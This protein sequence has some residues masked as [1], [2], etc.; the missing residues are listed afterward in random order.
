MKANQ[1]DLVGSPHNTTDTTNGQAANPTGFNVG[2]RVRH[3][4][5][6]IQKAR[7]YWLSCGREPMKT[8]ARTDLDKKTSARGTVTAVEQGKYSW[9]VAV[10]WDD[11][12]TSDGL[13]YMISNAGISAI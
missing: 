13:S 10:T 12:H 5:S 11:G 8:G 6:V 4:G 3:S 1:N 2:D 7:D 9:H